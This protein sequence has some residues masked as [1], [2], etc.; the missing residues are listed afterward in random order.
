MVFTCLLLI[1]RI[2]PVSALKRDS[3]HAGRPIDRKQIGETWCLADAAITLHQA[4]SKRTRGPVVDDPACAYSRDRGNGSAASGLRREAAG[5]AVAPG[6][7]RRH[8]RCS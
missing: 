5:G 2:S 4:V 7:R 3:S 6:V 1:R 8:D